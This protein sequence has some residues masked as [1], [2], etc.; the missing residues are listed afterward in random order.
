MLSG[1]DK[2]H[3]LSKSSSLLSESCA[4]TKAARRAKNSKT[5]EEGEIPAFRCPQDKL[6]IRASQAESDAMH[7]A[8]RS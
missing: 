5:H 8:R 6:L 7:Q 4:D 2:F 3:C 1:L